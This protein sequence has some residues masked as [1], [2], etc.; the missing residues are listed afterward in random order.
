M[1]VFILFVLSVVVYVS[2]NAV[3]NKKAVR[4]YYDGTE[5]N[6]S[7]FKVLLAV[8]VISWILMV[9]GGQLAARLPY[10]TVDSCLMWAKGYIGNNNDPLGTCSRENFGDTT[11]YFIDSGTVPDG[12]VVKESD[13]YRVFSFETPVCKY[14]VVEE[15]WLRI[16]VSI[17]QHNTAYVAAVLFDVDRV[18]TVNGEATRK[19][20]DRF[21]TF[22]ALVEKQDSYTIQMGN[23][24]VYIEL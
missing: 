12:Y 6:S 8:V 20:V 19:K 18:V 1:I 3:I 17:S 14:N 22:Y 11:V 10:K 15:S 13:G 16:E 23:E 9:V 24:T 7:G 5:F 21:V 4:A 2:L